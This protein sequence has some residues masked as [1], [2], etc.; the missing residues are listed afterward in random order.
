MVTFCRYNHQNFYIICMKPKDY[1]LWVKRID[2]LTSDRLP[3]RL[4][5][6]FN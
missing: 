6:R 3:F 1:G 2:E 4:T 5:P